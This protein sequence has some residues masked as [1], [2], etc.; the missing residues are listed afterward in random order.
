MELLG[1]HAYVLADDD[2]KKVSSGGKLSLGLGFQGE[3]VSLVGQDR[4]LA[5]YERAET[6][7]RPKVVIAGG[8]YRGKQ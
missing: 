7:Y 1:Y 4:L 5:L 6:C 8:V 2:V 3:L